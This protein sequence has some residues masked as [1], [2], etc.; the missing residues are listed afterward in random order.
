VEFFPSQWG[1]HFINSQATFYAFNSM[2][3]LQH[4]SPH[5]NLELQLRVIVNNNPWHQVH[6]KPSPWLGFFLT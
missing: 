2:N 6:P 4:I 3:I 5:T 1:K